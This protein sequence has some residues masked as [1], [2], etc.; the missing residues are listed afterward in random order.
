MFESA[1]CVTA[2]TTKVVAGLRLHKEYI[3]TV[4]GILKIMQMVLG[5]CG[6]LCITISDLSYHPVATWYYFVCLISFWS[7]LIML[8]CYSFHMVEKL[9]FLPCLQIELAF[10]CCWAALYLLAAALSASFSGT[11]SWAAATVFAFLGMSSH[12]WEA[13]LKLRDVRA[14]DMAQGQRTVAT[15]GGTLPKF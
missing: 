5:L 7:S 13:A 1:P 10:S 3:F 8:V 2:T 11:P 12:A 4:G 6:F 15:S 14:G 9:H